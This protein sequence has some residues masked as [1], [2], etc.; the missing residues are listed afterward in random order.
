[1]LL[2]EFI[3]RHALAPES[4]DTQ[5][6]VKQLL[7]EM[8]DGLAGK[9][10]IPMIPSWLPAHIQPETEVPCCV[11]D[12]GGT[13]L[14]I[15]RA[16]FDSQGKCRLSSLV[17]TAMP[18]TQGELHC[19]EFYRQLAEHVRAS[20]S[21]ERIGFCFSYSVVMN[22]EL[23]GILDAW[24]KE[25]RVPDA[26]GKPVGASLSSAVGESCRSVR[27]VNDSTAA[28]LGAHGCNPNITVGVILGTGVNTCYIESCSAIPKLP[29][30][31]P[32]GDM[33]VSTE[34]GEFRGIPKSTF[35]QAVI[36]ASD[37][38]AMAHAEK[39]CAGAYLGELI[40]RAWKAASEEG[41]LPPEFRRP[42]TLPQISDYLAKKPSGLPENANACIL[43]QVMVQ[44]AAKIAAILTAG[45]VLRSCRDTKDCTLVMEG[46]QFQ[47]LTGFA[48]CFRQELAA[49]LQHHGVHCTIA[50]MEDSCLKGAA[51]AAFAQTM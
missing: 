4:I 7:K 12:A 1:M 46:S 5:L 19:A 32:A 15:A 21:P 17:K 10:N 11:L 23:D 35:D 26:I 40:H 3:A 18:G 44:R 49:A 28:L 51:M 34:C 31:V 24:C 27:V 41:L 2:S 6:C 42:V 20:G 50:Q 47:K 38:P 9:G 13:N 16:E 43:A 14:R 29:E 30:P 37:D 8:E 33:I 45:T 36:A 39:Q 22:R 25:V 48:D